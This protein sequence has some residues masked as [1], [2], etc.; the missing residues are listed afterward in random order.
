MGG[1]GSL[2][3]LMAYGD[4]NGICMEMG[5]EGL[6]VVQNTPVLAGVNG[7]DPFRR[8]PVFLRQVREAGFS[9]V[10]KFPTVGL[11]DG[12]MR[13]NLEA[14]GM[15]YDKEVAMI[16]EA[17]A[18]DMFT[19]PYVFNVD[20]ARAMVEAGGDLIVAHMGLTTAGT[21]GAAYRTITQLRA[22]AEASGYQVEKLLAIAPE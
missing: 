1:G 2:G 11:F 8:M 16:A 4:A 15:G 3:W 5:G 21:I 13:V 6:P 22:A 14:T 12:L 9:G 20:E 7:T 18:Q 10:Q 19:S 17:H